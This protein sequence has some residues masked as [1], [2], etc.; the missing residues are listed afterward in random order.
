M[1]HLESLLLPKTIRRTHIYLIILYLWKLR[2]RLTSWGL[3]E[4]QMCEICKLW[5]IIRDRVAR[6]LVQASY[7]RGRIHLIWWISSAIPNW[8][9]IKSY[10]RAPNQ[11][12]SAPV[13]W[14]TKR[15]QDNLSQKLFLTLITNNPVDHLSRIMRILT[16]ITRRVR[17]KPMS[18]RRPIFTF[19]GLVA[20]QA[21]MLTW[22]HKTS[23]QKKWMFWKTNKRRISYHIST[24]EA[25]LAASPSAKSKI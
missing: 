12:L 21:A 7:H 9:S 8:H 18:M 10:P 16:T 13:Q 17:R 3:G 22:Q 6:L 11:T 2:N 15:K 14:Q 19:R 4:P 1:Q 25:N 5:R 23:S 24:K 20:S